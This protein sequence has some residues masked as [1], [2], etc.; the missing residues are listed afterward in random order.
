MEY[1]HAFLLRPMCQWMPFW[2]TYVI[3]AD[4]IDSNYSRKSYRTNTEVTRKKLRNTVER[5]MFYTMISQIVFFGILPHGWMDPNYTVWR[6]FISML[7]TEVLFFYSHRL[8]HHPKL[9]KYHKTHHEFIE[10]VAYAALYCHPFEAIFSNQL[11]VAVGPMITGM[12]YLE[13]GIWSVLCAVNT[14]K[15]HSG[16]RVKFFNSSYHDRHHDYRKVNFGFLYILDILHGTCD[17]TSYE[18]GED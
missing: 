15:A 8:L 1:I 13:I 16:L 10:P 18:D 11:A 5:N 2:L 3:L 14:I 12:S 17:L 6:I 4:Y 9:Y 7:I